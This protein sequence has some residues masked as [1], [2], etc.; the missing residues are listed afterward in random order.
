M[1]KKTDGMK[2]YI[3]GN[4][5]PFEYED[6]RRQTKVIDCHYIQQSLTN[7]NQGKGIKN[8]AKE[9][10]MNFGQGKVFTCLSVNVTR[11]ELTRSEVRQHLLSIK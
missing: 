5:Y 3:F 1:T 11:I 8:L 7:G 4:V 9:K 6:L 2:A 10:K